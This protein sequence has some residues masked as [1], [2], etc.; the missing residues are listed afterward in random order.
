MNILSIDD[1]AKRFRGFGLRDCAMGF[2][3]T[4]SLVLFQDWDDAKPRP[5]DEDLETRL[6][7]WDA[8]KAKW[9]TSKLNGFGGLMCGAHRPGSVTCV[10]RSGR[11][12]VDEGDTDEVE[13]EI[14]G[15]R[16]KGPMR[17]SVTKL[18][19]IDGGLYCA[20]T[21]R[22]L[23][24]RLGR[25]DW[26]EIGPLPPAGSGE[27][28]FMDFDAFDPSDIYA[29]GGKGDVWHYSGQAWK[30]I[31]FPSNM[32]IESVCCG[33]DGFVYIGA[34]SG[35]VFRGRGSQWKLIER[36]ELSLAFKDMVWFQDR[37]Y[38]T[39]DYGLWEI[40]GETVRRSDEPI[41]ITNCS[42]NLSVSDGVMLL[43][44]AYG[45]ALH[46][47]TRWTRLFSLAELARQSHA[48]K[49]S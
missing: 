8:S 15:G 3:G 32:W 33:A 17:G 42:G 6:C 35:T 49:P 48:A 43:A 19:K 39:S 18:K 20:G 25:N 7:V 24:K 14:P 31:A 27:V 37:V 30:K 9:T 11:V 45:A 22:S 29:A 36:G 40:K 4:L 16:G 5:F 12:F 2:G 10:D 38:A 28:G 41:E 13:K 44:G 46:D 34:Q 26:Q 1:Y 23:C 21:G 47:G